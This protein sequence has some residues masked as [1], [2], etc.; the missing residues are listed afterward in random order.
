MTRPNLH[1]SQHV[2]YVCFNQP[3]SGQTQNC[4]LCVAGRSTRAC[5][6]WCR[7]QSCH[8]AT[9]LNII[10]RK[11]C[12]RIIPNGVTNCLHSFPSNC[13]YF[14][15]HATSIPVS[16]FSEWPGRWNQYRRTTGVLRNDTTI[17]S[18]TGRCN[19]PRFRSVRIS[20]HKPFQAYLNGDSGKL[21]AKPNGRTALTD[22]KHPVTYTKEHKSGQFREKQTILPR[23]MLGGVGTNCPEATVHFDQ[24]AICIAENRGDKNIS[25]SRTTPQPYVTKKQGP[26]TTTW[27]DT[28]KSRPLTIMRQIHN[29]ETASTLMPS[30]PITVEKFWTHWLDLNNFRMDICVAL[31]WPNIDRKVPN[32]TYTSSILLFPPWNQKHQN[33]RRPKSKIFSAWTS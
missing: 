2:C 15:K 1:H 14:I 19:S 11:S 13:I 4:S 6:L 16:C 21:N 22:C 28:R 5:L 7:A 18:C 25:P 27:T 24:A 23:G 26:K 33:S 10:H 12:E 9:T 31:A 3:Y 30:T 20:P 17:L 8:T 32:C 29:G